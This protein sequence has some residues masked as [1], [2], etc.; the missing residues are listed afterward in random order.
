MESKGFSVK[1]SLAIALLASAAYSCSATAITYHTLQIN[2]AVGH[3][4]GLEDGLFAIRG[5]AT[6]FDLSASTF[7][8]FDPTYA[9]P[10]G[11]LSATY[12]TFG[13]SP[14][15]ADYYQFLDLT[16][17]WNNFST[18]VNT[19]GI[20]TVGDFSLTG[21]ALQTDRAFL[22]GA[23]SSGALFNISNAPGAPHT[24]TLDFNNQTMT[25][26][27]R[28]QYEYVGPT[29]AQ[30]PLIPNDWVGSLTEIEISPVGGFIL[31]APGKDDAS[32]VDFSVF[33]GALP[34][35]GSQNYL[36]LIKSHLPN[37]WTAAG[38]W[39]FGLV[40]DD[41]NTSG[42]FGEVS[43]TV[44]ASI[45]GGF[46]SGLS[47]FYTTDSF[48]LPTPLVEQDDDGFFSTNE[49]QDLIDNGDLPESI[50][51]LNLAGGEQA[52]IYE[53]DLV[54]GDGGSTQTL[55]F[56]YDDT[57]FSQ[58]DELLLAIYHYTGGVW[59]KPSQT[60]D[61][62]ANTITVTVDNFS[63]FALVTVPVPPAVYLFA[64]ALI[65]LVR[66]RRR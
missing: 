12:T 27:W 62:L 31:N 21:T 15:A 46:A 44:P 42:F 4:F 37:N 57:G 14:T 39:G 8:A 36:N 17:E 9:N 53:V 49:I 10:N 35:T 19:D 23:P 5:S 58:E 45:D 60:L 47:V 65:A 7:P 56:D 51:D 16:V 13:T 52:Q 66:V 55:V 64:T 50:K 30:N 48:I 59:E 6:D 32:V 25:G 34:P 24:F 29:P 40:H 38:I 61:T 22:T 3:G 11:A 28:S 2:D 18:N 26:N 54:V 41:N 63:P 43:A 1:G 20:Y 33:G